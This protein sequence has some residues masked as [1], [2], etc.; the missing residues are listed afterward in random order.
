MHVR[1]PARKQEAIRKQLLAAGAW[2]DAERTATLIRTCYV[3]EA[4]ANAVLVEV[5]QAG[6]TEVHRLAF[7]A[8]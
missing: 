2:G 4:V 7:L 1:I 5:A 8:M 3:T 6:S